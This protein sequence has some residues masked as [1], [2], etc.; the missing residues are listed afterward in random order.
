MA[1]VPMPGKVVLGFQGFLNIPAP[2][3]FVPRHVPFI[4][5]FY[6]F[7]GR[8]TQSTVLLGVLDSW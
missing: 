5:N 8:P 2:V 4:L 6:G 3:H 1:V 7:S